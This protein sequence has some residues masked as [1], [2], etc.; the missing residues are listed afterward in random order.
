MINPWA[1]EIRAAREPEFA[2]RA[3]PE[4][5]KEMSVYQTTPRSLPL[6]TL[7]THRV[8]SAVEHVVTRLTAW[9]RARQTEAA[10][11]DLSDA[12]LSDIGL[13]RGEITD[14]ADSLSRR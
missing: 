4:S 9:K 5:T 2:G 7:T 3:L 12:Q 1:N 11:R 10:L 13:R 8:V 14:F 6:G